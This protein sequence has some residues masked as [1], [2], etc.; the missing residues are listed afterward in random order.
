[1]VET[2]FGYDLLD[3]N[4]KICMS[5]TVVLLPRGVLMY[6]VY[7]NFNKLAVFCVFD[8]LKYTNDAINIVSLSALGISMLL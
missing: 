8:V 1:M 5:V 4:T 2:S 7:V 6:W 3:A